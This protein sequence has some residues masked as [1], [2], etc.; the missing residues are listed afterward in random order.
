MTGTTYTISVTLPAFSWPAFIALCCALGVGFLIG[1]AYEAARW[2][3][4]FGEERRRKWFGR[5]YSVR[6]E[7][8]E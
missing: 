2:M 4:R 8:K 3:V 1:R 5:V 7:G 6:Y